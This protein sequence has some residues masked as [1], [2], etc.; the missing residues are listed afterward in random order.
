MRIGGAEES[1][2]YIGIDTPESVIPGERPECFGKKAARLNERLVEGERVRLVFG[3][4]APRPLR[5]PAGLRLPP[6]APRQRPDPPPRLRPHPRDRAEHA[7]FAGNGSANAGRGRGRDSPAEPL[8]RLLAREG[9]M[10]SRPLRH[11]CAAKHE[12]TLGFL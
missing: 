3:R 8:G 11:A 2:R 7:T 6:R 10:Q 12:G 9:T 4:R 5:P 1:V